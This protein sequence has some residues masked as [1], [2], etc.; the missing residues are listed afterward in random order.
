MSAEEA[1]D[2][3]EKYLAKLKKAVNAEL[4]SFSRISETQLQEKDFERT[5]TQKIKRFLYSGKKKKD[6]K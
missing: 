4:S 6:E 5:P 1:K 3:A 2:F